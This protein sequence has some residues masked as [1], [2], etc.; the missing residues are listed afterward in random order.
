MEKIIF[1][2]IE[3]GSRKNSTFIGIDITGETPRFGARSLDDIARII[4]DKFGEDFEE[5]VTLQVPENISEPCYELTSSDKIL[6]KAL[7]EKCLAGKK[8]PGYRRLKVEKVIDN[9]PEGMEITF[10]DFGI[11]FVIPLKHII[12]YGLKDLSQGDIIYAK[13]K[14]G[15]KAA[16]FLGGELIEDI[17][18][19]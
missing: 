2:G 6:L 18:Y 9:G 5:H 4:A 14:K 11:G 10:I 3:H 17:Q 19:P 16:D 8:Y 12:K 1:V 15:I 13:G 7:I